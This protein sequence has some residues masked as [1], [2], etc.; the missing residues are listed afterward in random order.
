[1]T[2]IDKFTQ[3]ILKNYREDLSDIA[4]HGCSG[5]FSGLT[6]YYDTCKLYD[7]FSE[8][9][10]DRLAD[11]LE[12]TGSDLP[13]SFVEA[14]KCDSHFKN[15]MVWF[16]VENIAH[17]YVNDNEYQDNEENTEDNIDTEDATATD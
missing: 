3:Y 7:K 9:I 12:D 4:E 11:Y 14:L 8:E 5:G 2:N 1:M 15:W 10:H 16:A 13:E 6:S 17:D